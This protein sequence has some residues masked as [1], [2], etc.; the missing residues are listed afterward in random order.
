VVGNPGRIVRCLG[1]RPEIDLN[2]GDLPD[3]VLERFQA[4]DKTLA[5]LEEM[6]RGDEK[7]T[8]TL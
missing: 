8:P 1:E 6:A 3:P 2:H 5:R 4:A 7:E